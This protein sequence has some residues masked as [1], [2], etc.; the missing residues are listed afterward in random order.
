MADTKIDISK[1]KKPPK[2]DKTAWEELKYAADQVS[3]TLMFA[4]FR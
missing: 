1:R 3:N 4:P 2:L